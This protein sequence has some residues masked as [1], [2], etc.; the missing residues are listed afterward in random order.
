MTNSKST[1]LQYMCVYLDSTG[2][3]LQS[4]SILSYSL[5]SKGSLDNHWTLQHIH[6]VNTSTT[7]RD[8][9]WKTSFIVMGLW[10]DKLQVHFFQFKRETKLNLNTKQGVASLFFS[11]IC[12]MMN[13]QQTLQNSWNS[14]TV[15]KIKVN[16]RS[17]RSTLSILCQTEHVPSLF[18]RG[19]V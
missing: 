5:P 7:A 9:S 6:N 10:V 4:R 17:L 12:R 11:L 14:L 8:P 16:P 3:S 15:Y 19:R 18:Y 2:T 1:A 13:M